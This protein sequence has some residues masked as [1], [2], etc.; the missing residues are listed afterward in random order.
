MGSKEILMLKPTS[1]LSE[2]ELVEAKD[3]TEAVSKSKEFPIGSTFKVVD[4]KVSSA[5]NGKFALF[6]VFERVKENK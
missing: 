4:H 3:S 1:N 6:P 2:Y 5:G